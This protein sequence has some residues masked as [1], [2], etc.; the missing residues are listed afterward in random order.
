MG[1]K[2]GFKNWAL[3][4]SGVDGGD[5]G[6]PNNKSR[7]VCG[8]EWGAGHTPEELKNYLNDCPKEIPL[9][10]E[11]WQENIAYIFN[12]QVM[13]LFSA[14]SG[15][16]VDNYKK[17]AEDVKPF[18]RNEQGYFKMNL[19]PIAFKDTDEERWTN[20]FSEVTGLN[21]KQEYIDWCRLNRLKKIRE[22]TLVYSPE[23]VICLGKS[24]ADDFL[25]AYSDSDIKLNVE[26]IDDRELSW[27]V[28]SQ[29]S[30]VVI[31]P[32]M[33][34]RNG[35]VKNDSIQKFGNRIAELLNS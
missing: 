30:L 16:S 4:F 18:V 32:F 10:Y 19:Y 15:D 26:V 1:I 11:S 2:D 7:W 14:I 6:A 33:V 34:N 12:W 28:N 9:G 35:L 29:G 5:I 13:K 27:C 23:L 17:F 25:L 8:I 22:W 20:G 24:Y 21:S 31:L 3:G